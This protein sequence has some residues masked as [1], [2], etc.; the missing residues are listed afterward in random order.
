MFFFNFMF[1]GMQPVMYSVR[2]ALSGRPGWIRAGDSVC[3][4]R[5]LYTTNPDQED[6]EKAKKR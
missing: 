5:N 4:Y 6:N 1:V 3:Y 2:E